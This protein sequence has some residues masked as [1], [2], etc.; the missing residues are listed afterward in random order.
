ME[1]GDC[2]PMGAEFHKFMDSSHQGLLA[3]IADKKAIDDTLKA[4][5]VAAIKEFKKRFAATAKAT[6]NTRHREFDL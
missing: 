1:V 4:D 2:K 3:R 5:M 6:A